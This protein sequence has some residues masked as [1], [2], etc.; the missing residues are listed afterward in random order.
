M[1]DEKHYLSC[2]QICYEI[3]KKLVEKKVITETNCIFH[4][5][6]QFLSTEYGFTSK[7]TKTK[8][9]KK[10]TKNLKRGFKMWF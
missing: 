8:K 4:P 1:F 5:T 6:I 3:V 2:K 9:K 10:K 7:K